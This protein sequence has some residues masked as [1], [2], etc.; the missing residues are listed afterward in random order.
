MAV[1]FDLATIATDL[2]GYPSVTRGLATNRVISIRPANANEIAKFPTALTAVTFNAIEG[3]SSRAIQYLSPTAT[4][5]V[6][7]AVNA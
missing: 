3:N 4:A 1:T 5:D 2:S 7:T 6:K